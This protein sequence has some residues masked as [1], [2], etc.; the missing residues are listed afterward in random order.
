M[1]KHNWPRVAKEGESSE[2]GATLLA[3]GFSQTIRNLN[4]LCVRTKVT[5][6]WVR[7]DFE[8]YKLKSAVSNKAS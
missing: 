7:S 2:S 1:R 6:D 3:S 8:T 5:Q 4:K